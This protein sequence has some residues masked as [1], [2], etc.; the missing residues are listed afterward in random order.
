MAQYPQGEEKVVP[1]AAGWTNKGAE[2][3]AALK[4][5]TL[6]WCTGMGGFV[7]LPTSQGIR[8][9]QPE[10]AGISL[11]LAL[12]VL[13]VPHHLISQPKDSSRISQGLW[14]LP[15]ARRR[16]TGELEGEVLGVRRNR[17]T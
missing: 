15:A 14:H 5:E 1:Q 4:I 12:P 6:E 7:H 16:R 17:K 10:A 13:L 8:R 2:R 9:N 3:A 11:A